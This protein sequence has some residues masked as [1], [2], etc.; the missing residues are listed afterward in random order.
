MRAGRLDNV[1]TIQRYNVVGDDGAG[2][3][4]REWFV[5]A[6]MRAQLVKA[7]TEELVRQYGIDSNTL[8]VFRT[9]FMAGITTA[10]R[11][12]HDGLLHDIKEIKEI[13]RR[14]GLEIGT[15]SR[16]DEA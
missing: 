7:S 9:R 11:V 16:G 6:T 2:N 8:I 12:V 3:Q 1:I 13:G 14:K 5:L 4:I 10:D 15:I